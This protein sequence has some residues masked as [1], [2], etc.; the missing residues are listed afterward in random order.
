MKAQILTIGDELLIGQVVN[1]N[2]SFIAEKLTGI[3]IEI[4]SILT[5]G[6][7]QKEIL[8]AL[9]RSTE[10]YDLTAITG[11]LGPTHDDVTRAAICTFFGRSL[12]QHQPTLANIQKLM[13]AR[14][15]P[16]SKESGDQALVPEG[17]EVI[18]NPRGTAPGLIIERDGHY[19]VV[20]PGVPY[21]MELMVENTVVP[22]FEKRTKTVIRQRTLR[23][24][25]ISETMLARRCGDIEALLQGEKLAFLPSPSGVRMRIT[26]T[27]S[28]NEAVEKKLQDI[29]SRIREK[30][31]KYI[32]GID[33]ESFEQVLGKLLTERNLKISVAESCTGGLIA[34]RITDVSG[35]SVYFDRGVIAYSN[36]SKIEILKVDPDII[37]RYGAVSEQTAIAMANGVRSISNSDIGIS[38]TGIA[39]PT[40]GSAE[41]PVGLVWIGYSDSR[42][43]FA[44]KF[45]LGEDRLRV[46]ERAAQ[47][48]LELVRRRILN[49]E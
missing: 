17:A 39:G 46:K 14:Q 8:A 41:K 43:S 15:L 38:T 18:P 6:D 10:L 29:E 12:V 21:E 22:Y 36:R 37:D 42:D 34:D 26:V 45:H 1:T 9:T 28:E 4:K 40:G 47:A 24:T 44:L 3:G 33:N 27:G 30:A 7:D 20:M 25:G 49:I 5:V 31:E 35:S 19:V 23:T 11:G 13:Q 16:W 2:A 48:A 32:Y